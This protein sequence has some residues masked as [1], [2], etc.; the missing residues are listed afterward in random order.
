MIIFTYVVT[1]LENW[2]SPHFKAEI[3]LSDRQHQ[4]RL[5]NILSL[6]SANTCVSVGCKLPQV[7]KT[8]TCPDIKHKGHVLS[9]QTMWETGIKN[10]TTVMLLD[11]LDMLLNILQLQYYKFK[12]KHGNLFKVNFYCL[13]TAFLH[14]TLALCCLW[15]KIGWLSLHYRHFF[16]LERIFLCW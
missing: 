7:A 16:K 2:P 1:I 11:N 15:L 6:K 14:F 4:K 8:P 10:S 3:N 12:S 9:I 5:E 13:S